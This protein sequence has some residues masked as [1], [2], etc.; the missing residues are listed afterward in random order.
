[1]S[2][3]QLQVT[4][5]PSGRHVYLMPGSKVLEGAAR[6]GLTINTPCGGGGTCGKCRVQFLS[7]AAE[8][9]SSDRGIFSA[10]ELAAGWRLACQTAFHAPAVVHVPES[11]LFGSQHQIVSASASSG[12]DEVDPSVRKVY[13]E[14]PQPSLHD[15]APDLFRVEREIGALKVDLPLL[16]AL[17]RRVRDASF[18][19]T[20]VLTDHHLIDFE[21]GDTTAACYGAAFDIGTT[22]IAGALMD[23]RTGSELAVESCMNPQVARGDDVLSRISFASEGPEQLA[24]MQR[25]V[26]DAVAGLISDMCMTANVSQDNIY[27][28]SFAGNTTME[29]LLCGIDP[30][31]LGQVPFVPAYGRGLMV[32]A[33]ELG[34]PIHPRGLAYLFPLIG[35]F[36][37]GDIVAGLLATRLN[38]DEGPILMVDI[39]TNGEIVLCA[40]GR[41]LGSSTAAGPAFEGARISCGMRATRGAIEKVVIG[42]DITLSVIGDGPARGI[43]G[44]GLI[45]LASELLRCGVIAESGAILT[46]DDLPDTVSP[47]V[48]DR[49]GLDDDGEPRIRL[50]DGA[51]PD[52]SVW[53]TQRDVRELQLASAAIRAG[54]TILV[55]QAGVE[56]TDIRSVLIAG[57]FGSFIRRNHA[58]RIGLIPPGIEHNRIRHVGNV[59]LAGARWALVSRTAREQAEE[60]ARGVEHVELSLDMDFQMK[61]AESMYFPPMEDHGRDAH[62]T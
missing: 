35:G 1:M 28:V 18:K 4:F 60:L 50:D 24:E 47:A 58:L 42:E 43:C 30:I 41:M 7:G 33:A 26:R 52:T 54:I 27:E 31:Q 51:A 8:P 15:S 17:P 32:P 29:H 16:R 25:L 23:L 61:F 46:G 45:D 62:A 14:L 53:L 57:G 12:E 36:I 10:A 2:E 5:Q 55:Q 56:I 11:S 40:G 48:R 13:V 49:A 38:C 39:G 21:P 44:S 34:I 9:C 37:G 22:T 3:G 59:S 6:A 20:A 19:G